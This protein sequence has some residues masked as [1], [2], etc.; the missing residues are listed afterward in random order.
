MVF[1]S[2]EYIYYLVQLH[3][4]VQKAWEYLKTKGNVTGSFAPGNKDAMTQIR[5]FIIMESRSEY[6]FV[7]TYRGKRYTYSNKLFYGIVDLN[8]KHDKSPLMKYCK[9][10]IGVLRLK[11]MQKAKAR[12]QLTAAPQAKP[13]AAPAQAA[14]AA[15]TPLQLKDIPKP[16]PKAARKRR[17]RGGD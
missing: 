13:Q 6:P 8:N 1:I 7:F 5:T 12:H 9:E 17:K 11:Y 15:P 14:Q 3:N 10:Q 4:Y 16:K 2:N